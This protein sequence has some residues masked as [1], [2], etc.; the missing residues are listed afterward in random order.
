MNPAK[1]YEDNE[2]IEANVSNKEKPTELLSAQNRRLFWDLINVYKFLMQGV[3]KKIKER[4]SSQRDLA[5]GQQAHIKRQE[6]PLKCK[7]KISERLI[8]H[9]SSCPDTWCSLHPWGYSEPD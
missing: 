4:E 6:I 7:S 8:K 2:G 3:T 5:T 9:W 1:G